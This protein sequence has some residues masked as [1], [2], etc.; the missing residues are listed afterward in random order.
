[1]SRWN[2]AC[3]PAGPLVFAGRSSTPARRPA[4]VLRRW[5]DL[6]ETMPDQLT[7]LA[8]ILIA[9]PVP[10]LPE[11]VHGQLWSGSSESSGSSRRRQ[12]RPA[13]SAPWAS[14]WL[15]SWAH[16]HTAMQSLLDPL[17]TP[18]PEL[19]HRR[20]LSGLTDETIDT[21]W[22]GTP[23]A[24]RRSGSCNL[25]HCGAPWPG[26]GGRHRLRAPQRGVRPQIIAVT[27]SRGVPA[28]VG[29]ARAT[30]RA[31]DRGPPA[32]AYVNFTSDPG[33]DKVQASIPPDTYAAGR[34]QGPVRPANLFQL[35]EHPP[36]RP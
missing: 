27:R 8:D 3:T 15:T 17:W 5:H 26:P 10:F 1:V 33:T 29:W 13:R 36:L 18:G 31:V 16:A 23:P 19:F 14:P 11:A 22:P 25:H 34:G 12:G 20:T 24:G 21:L 30:P 35:T 32:G 2:S 4:G 7:T 6:T 28:H 9:P